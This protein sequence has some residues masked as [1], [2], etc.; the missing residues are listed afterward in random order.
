MNKALAA[1][2]A[3]LLSSSA[4][5]GNT[6]E[7]AKT[8][9]ACVMPKITSDQSYTWKDRGKSA[10]RLISECFIDFDLWEKGCE[11]ERRSGVFSCPEQGILL[12]Q[13]LIMTM[14]CNEGADKESCDQLAQASATLN[15]NLASPP[16]TGPGEP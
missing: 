14:R 2:S 4:Y 13:M 3:A 12:T 9:G 1:L 11:A 16:A 6:V 7:R 15:E 8:Y 5:G 10:G